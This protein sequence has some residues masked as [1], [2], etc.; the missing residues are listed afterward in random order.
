MLSIFERSSAS[1]AASVCAMLA[2][3]RSSL[4]QQRLMHLLLERVALERRAGRYA[5]S[6]GRSSSVA[7]D[8][9]ERHARVAERGRAEGCS[10]VIGASEGSD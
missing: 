7:V 6:R 8:A 9:A 1:F 10:D 2:E 5:A 4:S 3:T